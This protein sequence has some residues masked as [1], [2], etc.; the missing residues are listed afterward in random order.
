MAPFS[1]TVIRLAGVLMLL[2]VTAEPARASVGGYVCSVVRRWDNVV[3]T[4]EHGFLYV[5]V[6]SGH[7]CSGTFQGSIWYRSTGSSTCSSYLLNEAKMESLY[8]NLTMAAS[9]GLQVMLG[10]DAVG[11][12]GCPVAVTIYGK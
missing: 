9:E 12:A 4:G 7:A 1:R 5:T 8:Q 3:D 11:P 2:A 6:Y 10:T